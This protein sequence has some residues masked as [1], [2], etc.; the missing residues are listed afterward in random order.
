[1]RASRLA[2]IGTAAF[3]AFVPLASPATKADSCQT[4]TRALVIDLDNQRH[5]RILDHAWDAIEAGEKKF[6][7]I[8]CEHAKAHRRASLRGIPTRQGYDRDEY[9]PAASEEGGEGADIRYVKSAE[10]RSAGSLMG[11]QLHGWCNGQRFRFEN[12]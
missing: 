4:R 2:L 6:L 7:H 1:M 8:D 5:A 3:T 10:N 9:P 11:R 12:P